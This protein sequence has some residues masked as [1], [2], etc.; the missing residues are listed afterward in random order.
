MKFFYIKDFLLFS[1]MKNSKHHIF[2][3][4]KGVV[5][6]FKSKTLELHTTRSWDFMG[7][8]LDYMTPKLLTTPQQ[9]VYGSHDVIVG[10]FDTGIPIKIF[11]PMMFDL[12][13][14]KT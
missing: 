8:P 5:S 10:V 2:V 7:L 11:N 9:S 1:L 14:P 4:I 3:G 6:V 13:I 12:S